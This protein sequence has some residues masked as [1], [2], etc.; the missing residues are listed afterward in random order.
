LLVALGVV[1]EVDVSRSRDAQAGFGWFVAFPFG[2]VV[3]AA[4]AVIEWLRRGVGL[5][6]VEDPIR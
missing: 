2:L 3:P 5:Q 6:P 4:A 1:S